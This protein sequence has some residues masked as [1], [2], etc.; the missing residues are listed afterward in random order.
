MSKYRNTLVSP[1]PNRP[2][3]YIA[4]GFTSHGM[5][6]TFFAGRNVADVLAGKGP[7]PFVREAFLPARF[8]L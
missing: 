1:L 2:G 3:A 6:M 7:R 4:A 5:P 8:A